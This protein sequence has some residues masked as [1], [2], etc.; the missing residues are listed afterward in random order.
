MMIANTRKEPT[1][2][3]R[4]RIS[5]VI[6]TVLVTVGVGAMA[7]TFTPTGFP[8]KVSPGSLTA[9]S[10]ID[11]SSH[12]YAVTGEIDVSAGGAVS[13]ARTISPQKTVTDVSPF[14]VQESLS[15]DHS[16]LNNPDL[17]P[18]PNPAPMAVAAYD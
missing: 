2:Q 10:G 15:L 6:A 12:G 4:G 18:E 3:Q 7:L 11:V 5:V 8:P 16:V 14:V 13:T 9:V 1:G 17:L